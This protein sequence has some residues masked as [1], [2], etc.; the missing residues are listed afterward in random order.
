MSN[1]YVGEIRMFAGNYAPAGWAFC[2]GS[3][4]AISS[5]E[6]LYS[7]IGTTYGG[8]GQTNFALPDLRS[9]V[10]VHAGPGFVIGLSGGAETLTTQQIPVHSHV[11][12]CNSATGNN[13]NPT[14]NVWATSSVN[15]Y[16]NGT[17]NLGMA[18]QAIG[19][20]GGSLPHDNMLPFLAI[21]FIVALFGIYPSQ[22]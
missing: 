4:L 19:L 7:L 6:A 10:P 8:N 20:A 2:D 5:Y 13:V 16:S 17:A 15:P 22:S 12:N 9:R 21:N 11:P 3:L 18:Q 14:M 1:Q